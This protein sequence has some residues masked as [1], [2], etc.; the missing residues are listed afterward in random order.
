MDGKYTTEKNQFTKG[1][2]WNNTH[3]SP[4][5]DVDIDLD[6]VEDKEHDKRKK[7]Q[8]CDYLHEFGSNTTHHGVR[9][10]TNPKNHVLRRLFW[11]VLLLAADSYLCYE[12]VHS[13]IRFYDYDVHTIVG[14]KYVPDLYFPAVTICNYNQMRKSKASPIV[15]SLNNALYSFE[16][17]LGKPINWTIYEDILG[18]NSS[19]TDNF[20][21]SIGYYAHQLN[22][23]VYDCKWRG[24]EP[25]DA[26]NFT[27]TMT[28]WGVCW[29][30]N[31][32]KNKSEILKINQPG[33]QNGLLLTMDVQQ[34]EYVSGET[35]AAGFKVLLHPQGVRPVLKELGFSISPGFETSVTVIY[36]KAVNLPRPYSNCRQEDL[37]PLKYS[38]SYTVPLC[39][40]ECKIDYVVRKCGCRDYRYPGDA[41]VCGPKQLVECI[42]YNEVKFVEENIKCDCNESCSSANY[43]ARTSIAYYPN[44]HFMSQITATLNQSEEFIR[45]N[46]LDLRIFFEELSFN[47]VKQIEAYPWTSLISDI[48]GTMGL[49]VGMSLITVV[50]VFDFLLVW[51]WKRFCKS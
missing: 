5:T 16:A 46:Y 20:V 17:R 8:F 14:V 40:Q 4:H 41:P 37:K 38:E 33:K 15:L 12:V 7:E 50:E 45:N 10:V 30:F 26:R 39:Q 43:G 19:F 13:F 35:D 21:D 31:D 3:N 1:D 32:P 2:Y 23:T 34:Y 9:Y 29:T 28:D 48:G 49:M 25:C 6:N 47:S 27:T 22:E 11:A 42:Y 24:V 36:T 44:E 18:S 51:I